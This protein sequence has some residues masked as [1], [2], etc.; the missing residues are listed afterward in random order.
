MPLDRDTI[1]FLESGQLAMYAT[2]VDATLRPRVARVYGCRFTEDGAKASVWVARPAA[3]RLLDAL[4][5]SGRLAVVGSHI[6]TLK[7][8]QLKSADARAL[9]AAP[10]D[11]EAVSAYCEAFVRTGIAAGYREPLLRS[12]IDSDSTAM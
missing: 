6:A 10:A 11:S 8:F 5:A 4:A 7:T 12:V 2:C 1:R 3:D 9:E